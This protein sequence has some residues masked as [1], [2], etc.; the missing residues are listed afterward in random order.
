M[1]EWISSKDKLPE[2]YVEVLGGFLNGECHVIAYW[3]DS[4]WRRQLD[5]EYWHPP[6]HWMPL[7]EVPDSGQEKDISQSSKDE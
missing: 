2:K 4:D 5:D 3:G 1:S 6:T 7:P